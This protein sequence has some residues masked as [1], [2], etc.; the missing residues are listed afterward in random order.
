VLGDEVGRAL[1]VGLADGGV[2]GVERQRQ[3]A[4][5]GLGDG[6]IERTL[7]DA[8]GLCFPE[9]RFHPHRLVE[10]IRPRL[11]LE[12]HEPVEVEDVG[13]AAEVLQVG[14]L[15]RGHGH[16]AGDFLELLRRK[17]LAEARFVQA[18]AGLA[19]G[20]LDHVVELQDAALAGLER[21]AVGP[22]HGAEADVLQL[23]LGGVA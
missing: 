17:V 8:V 14:E 23:S 13:G 16:L 2:E 10:E 6:D 5:G 15:E 12:A 19:A 22:V 1:V 7:P 3:V 4:F 9:Q 11:A 21:L 20:H 18:L